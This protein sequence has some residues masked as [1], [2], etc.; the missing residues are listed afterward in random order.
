MGIPLNELQVYRNFEE[1][2]NDVLQMANEFMQD[3]VVYITTMTDSK[4]TILK[5]LDNQ[6]GS[7]IPEG[8]T[9]DLFQ[10]VCSRVFR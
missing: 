9:L 6:T 8:L 2:A 3:R 5:V 10:T 4:Q 1:M 7:L